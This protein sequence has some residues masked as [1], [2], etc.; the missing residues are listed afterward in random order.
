L[1]SDF[2]DL[3]SGVLDSKFAVSGF[4]HAGCHHDFFKAWYGVWIG[5]T[6]F[7]LESR[8]GFLAVML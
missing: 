1:A 6:Q 8:N 3:V 2:S 4:A 7:F 5:V